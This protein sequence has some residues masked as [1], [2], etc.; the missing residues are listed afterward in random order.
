M[1]STDFQAGD[2]VYDVDRPD[3]VFR[4]VR[5]LSAT[6]AQGTIVLVSHPSDRAKAAALDE[7][8]AAER[9]PREGDVTFFARRVRLILARLDGDQ[10]YVPRLG[11]RV[12]L[13]GNQRFTGPGRIEI[14]DVV[15]SETNYCVHMDTGKKVWCEAGKMARLDDDQE[16]AD[17]K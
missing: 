4:M 3:L 6:D 1:A 9:G 15:H 7:I 16:R 8:R 12:T 5:P 2:I 13:P 14:V 11:D 17:G 10:H